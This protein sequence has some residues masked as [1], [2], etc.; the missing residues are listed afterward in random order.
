M[1]FWEKQKQTNS[2]NG[3]KGKP[4]TNSK[5]GLLSIGKVQLRSVIS[6][7]GAGWAILNQKSRWTPPGGTL[8]QTSD[9]RR[10]FQTQEVVAG[11]MLMR[12]TV[13]GQM[14]RVIDRFS[15]WMWALI[16]KTVNPRFVGKRIRDVSLMRNRKW[17]LWGPT[18]GRDS[19]RFWLETRHALL[20]LS[21]WG[22]YS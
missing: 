18:T 5:L 22:S 12:A 10:P 8:C 20:E 2:K 16:G 14:N 15:A 19:T 6:E 4:P 11:R 21:R 17:W 13:L 9:R 1:R 7:G 3:K